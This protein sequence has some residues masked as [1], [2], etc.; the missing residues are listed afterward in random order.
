MVPRPG[1]V[2]DIVFEPMDFGVWERTGERVPVAK[3]VT[4]ADG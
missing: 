2:D 3:P 1:Q 4:V